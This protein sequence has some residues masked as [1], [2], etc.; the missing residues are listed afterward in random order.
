MTTNQ[1]LANSPVEKWAITVTVMLVAVIDVLDITI[2]TVALRE[3]MGAF[4]ANSSQITWVVTAYVVASAIV[5]P[6]T[7]FLVGNFGRRKVLLVT[8]I[9]F[10]ITSVL[11][12]LSTNLIEIITFRALQGLFAASL[13]PLSQL[14]LRETFPPKQLDKAMAIWA[15]GIMVGPI[16]GPALGGYI[17]QHLS[18]HWIFFMNVPVCVIAFILSIGLIKESPL[19]KQPID[20]L[21]LALLAIGVGCLQ[22]FIEEGYRYNW[23]AS[24]T[25]LFL[26]L[27]AIFAIAAFLIHSIGNPH[28]IVKMSIFRNLQFTTCTVIITIYTMFLFG[29]IIL[30]TLM[31]EVV[32]RYPP[33]QTGLIMVPRGLAALLTMPL[34]PTLLKFLNAKLIIAIGLI[35]SALGT[36]VMTGWNLQTN[37]GTLAWESGIQGIGMSFVLA[38][39]SI[40]VFDTLTEADTA[41]ASGMFSF[42]RSIGLSI[43][44]ALLTTVLTNETQINWHRL[45]SYL[46]Q[47]NSNFIHWLN[48]QN[49]SLHNP[50]VAQKLSTILYTQSTMISFLDVYWIGGIALLLMLPLVLLIPHGRVNNKSI[51]AH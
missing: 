31:I 18:W 15:M 41:A 39:L 17:T 33:L 4:G 3:M 2:V 46:N 7:G 29:V 27:L 42:G 19:H 23:F 16:I 25:L 38:T 37:M 1:F 35:I 34:I 10:M 22:T 26:F 30:Q 44:V 9:G 49:L 47:F 14:I 40:I 43:G 21:G 24:H 28:S 48:V 32:I 12:G 13:I 45:G 50:I 51:G 36:F 11:C 8:I 5:M 6:L 20:W